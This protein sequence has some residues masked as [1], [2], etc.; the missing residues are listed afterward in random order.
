MRCYVIPK[1]SRPNN[2]HNKDAEQRIK[3]HSQTFNTNGQTHPP[4]GILKRDQADPA[5]LH[6]D[7]K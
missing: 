7:A 4:P 3:E 2:E 6:E 1:A 5:A